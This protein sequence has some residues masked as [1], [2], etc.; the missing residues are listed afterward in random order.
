MKMAQVEFVAVISSILKKW[1][2]QIATRRN[3][4]PEAARERFSNT[5]AI[6][7][8]GLTMQMVRPRDAVVKWVRR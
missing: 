5:V 1:K 6:S 8:P 3:E 4:T 2:V 7:S